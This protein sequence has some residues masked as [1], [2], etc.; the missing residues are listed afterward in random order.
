MKANKYKYV[1]CDVAVCNNMDCYEIGTSC[2]PGKVI[3]LSLISYF[4]YLLC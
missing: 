3:I 2:C 4:F 1:Q